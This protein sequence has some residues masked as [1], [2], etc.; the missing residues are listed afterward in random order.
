MAIGG[1]RGACRSSLTRALL[2]DG[3]HRAR[4][5]APACSR[6]QHTTRAS[7]VTAANRTLE[8]G[9][10]ARRATRA[11]GSGSAAAVS[12]SSGPLGASWRRTA[13]RRRRH[14]GRAFPEAPCPRLRAAGAALQAVQERP[15]SGR[16]Q[17]GARAWRA[18]LEHVETAPLVPRPG[19]RVDGA[20]RR[21]RRR[22]RLSAHHL[23]RGSGEI[24]GHGAVEGGEA[25]EAAGRIEPRSGEI[26]AR[27]RRDRT[28][29]PLRSTPRRN[30]RERGRTA[31]TRRTRMCAE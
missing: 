20:V 4:H 21:E 3:R 27:S 14:L 8:S 23:R 13:G 2:P 16:D 22:V 30:G 24:V 25:S 7:A 17:R 9:A 15:E 12:T 6:S 18:A 5:S 1:A 26:E 10:A 31:P 11:A 19:P 28:S 29:R